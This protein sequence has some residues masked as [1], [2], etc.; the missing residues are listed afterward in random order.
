MRS[1]LDIILEL[2]DKNKT[3]FQQKFGSIPKKYPVKVSY[4]I[5]CQKNKEEKLFENLLTDVKYG[6]IFKFTGSS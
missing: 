4:F 3:F 2:K 6:K 5:F 1:F